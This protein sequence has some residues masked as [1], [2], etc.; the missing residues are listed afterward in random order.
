[1][2]VCV[3]V[4][5]GW[6]VDFKKIYNNNLYKLLD[7][8]SVHESSIIIFAFTKTLGF[9]QMA[10]YALWF[11]VSYILY[12]VWTSQIEH[13]YF[14]LVQNVKLQ[15]IIVIDLHTSN[16]KRN[17]H[18]FLKPLLWHLRCNT[19]PAQPFSRFL[20]TLPPCGSF[21]PIHHTCSL[22]RVLHKLVEPT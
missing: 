22:H 15:H 4:H 8:C 16:L 13:N 10:D 6:N 17:T 7:S 20:T 5:L 18:Q 19:I 3:C 11:R 2:C 12:T 1:M 21:L 14:S 9:L